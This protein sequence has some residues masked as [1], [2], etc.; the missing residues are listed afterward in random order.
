MEE[1]LSNHNT[2]TEILIQTNQ[3]HEPSFNIILD[4]NG[5]SLI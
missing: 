4:G 1:I 5:C 3:I 2:I